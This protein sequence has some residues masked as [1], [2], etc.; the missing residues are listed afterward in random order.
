MRVGLTALAMG[1]GMAGCASQA[2]SY[3][4]A[5]LDGHR[6]EVRTI[7][8]GGRQRTFILAPGKGSG[9]RP[10]MLVYHGGGGTA[11]AILDQTAIGLAGVDAGMV[12]ASLEAA[13]GTNGRWATSPRD[14][15]TVDDLAF[16]R[17]VVR[18]IARSVGI[19][20]NRILAVGYSRGAEFTY[21]LAC[22]AP[23][24][25]RAIAA[26]AGSFP[27]AYRPW[28][29]S[30]AAMRRPAAMLASGAADPVI[31]WSRGT[32]ARASVLESARYFA[33]RN[34]CTGGSTDSLPGRRSYWKVTR[35]RFAPCEKADAV[36]F[37]ID[38]LEHLWPGSAFDVERAIVDW[39]LALP[40]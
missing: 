27:A 11:Q 24:L 32:P 21:Q 4:A 12:V 9:A 3:P 38:P 30:T 23:D 19:D 37:K 22:R 10:L 33:N 16:T 20:T 26:V 17:A 8:V 7:D 31:S 28:C 35:T 34:G 14:L 6:A 15:G 13:S 1:L 5:R 25:V 29:D 36:L 40:R 2:V 18:E 39:F